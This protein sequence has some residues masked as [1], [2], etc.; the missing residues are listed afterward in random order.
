MKEK[1]RVWVAYYVPINGIDRQD[2]TSYMNDVANAL[3]SEDD[4]VKNIFIP[5]ENGDAHIDLIYDPKGYRNKNNKKNLKKVK[6][7]LKQTEEIL[8][9][10]KTNG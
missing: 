4:S 10:F 1:D 7:L 3:K 8:N 6:E 5:I 2:V 9:S